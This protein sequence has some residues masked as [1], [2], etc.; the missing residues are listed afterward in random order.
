MTQPMRVAAGE[1]PAG[2]APAADAA[3][4]MNEKGP[5][6]FRRAGQFREE[7]PKEGSAAR[8]PPA[9]VSGGFGNPMGG[10]RIKGNRIRMQ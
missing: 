3:R 5:H 6:P 7:T 2:V 4:A 10:D 1:H 8:R 9:G